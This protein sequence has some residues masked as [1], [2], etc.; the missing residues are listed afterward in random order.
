VDTDRVHQV[1]TNL[2]NDG[3]VVFVIPP[4]TVRTAGQASSG[5]LRR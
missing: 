4:K 5:T 1:L 2:W 3:L